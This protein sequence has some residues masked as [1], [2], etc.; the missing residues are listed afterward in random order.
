MWKI[1]LLVL[2]LMFIFL[3]PLSSRGSAAAEDGQPVLRAAVD[4]KPG[5]VTL[6]S[7][8]MFLTAYIEL[9]A[10]YC[11]DAGKIDVLH[12]R[13][14]IRGREIPAE[15][16][17]SSVG[18]YDRDGV[19]DLMV[20]FDSQAVQTH[21]FAGSETLTIQGVISG[22]RDVRFRGSDTIKV[23]AGGK[24]KRIT[25]LQTSDLHHHAVG[26]GP[27]MDYTPLDTTDKDEVLGGFARLA[28]AIERVRAE[29]AE[30]GVPVVLVDSGDFLMG[31]AYDLAAFYPLSLKFFSLMNYDAA[32]L[33]NHE[34]DSSAAGLAMLLTNAIE[35]GFDVPVLATNTF[36][37]G[38]KGTSD[39]GIE[40][41]MGGGAIVDR[42]V[43][44]LSNGLNIGIMGLMGKDADEKA[45]AAAPV[46]FDHD[47]EFIQGFVDDLRSSDNA[48]LVLALSHGGIDT[49]GR[50]DD[51]RLAEAVNGIDVI[52]SGHYHT[53]TME[54]FLRGPSNTIIF[55]P[56]EYG[57]WLSRLDITYDESLGRVVDYRFTLIPIDD[58]IQGDPHTQELVEECSEAVDRMIARLGVGLDSAVSCIDFP[59]VKAPLQETGIGNLAADSIRSTATALAS[60]SGGKPCDM[61]IV[62]SGVIRDDVF[63][64]RLGIIM[65]S[66][67]YN[68]LPLGFSP[69]TSQRLPGYP[70]VSIYVTAKD[71]YM[72][73][74]M[75]LTI[76]PTLGPDY[77]LNFS[78]VRI[79]YDPAQA[80]G[81]K[82]VR[83]VYVCPA[84]DPFCL[85]AGT[86]LDRGDTTRLYHVVLDLYALQ[87]MQTVNERLAPYGLSVTLR[88]VSGDP[89][90]PADYLNYCIDADPAPGV[91][92]LKEWMALWK[93]LG[94]FF[95]AS[96][97]GI[98]ENLYGAGGM[99]LGRVRFMR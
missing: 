20:K 82:G 1:P 31:T 11:A 65:F 14:S 99:A 4:V 50:G 93:F 53:T 81:L 38:D 59:L 36:T 89:V 17:P 30:A 9:P 88:N 54:A 37:D 73:C 6:G 63:P 47:P 8:G 40:A 2:G 24:G 58:T 10:P 25:I 70:L 3:I 39:D 95:P 48:D 97:E 28:A 43:R 7:T 69:D 51:A 16:E 87:M 15:V 5:T 64:G 45:P 84:Q 12:V 13:L 94:T 86:P 78:G 56:G 61:G 44:K 55:S 85:S 75:G 34:F 19:L 67:V 52:A 22:S 80:R 41:L 72:I 18:D 49:N 23:K 35:K 74:E 71:L 57:K 79:D 42:H 60:S 32:A 76:A 26:Y 96:G 46:T 77:Y 21:L 33:G 68:M 90:H 83:T 91:Q 98:P 92:E 62:A 27:F 66:D 29:Q